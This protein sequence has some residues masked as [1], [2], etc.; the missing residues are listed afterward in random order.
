MRYVPLSQLQ[1]LH[2]VFSFE[3]EIDYTRTCEHKSNK[4]NERELIEEFHWFTETDT[5][6][7]MYSPFTK[8]AKKYYSP[9]WKKETGLPIGQT[10]DAIFFFHL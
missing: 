1:L 10:N 7:F 5:N 8:I 4:N 3:L 6:S 9:N 2:S